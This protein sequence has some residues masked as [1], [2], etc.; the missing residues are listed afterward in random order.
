MTLLHNRK[1]RFAALVATLVVVGNLATTNP[2][3]ADPVDD[4]LAC[5]LV[6]QRPTL[7]AFQVTG[8]GGSVGC[9]PPAILGTV[10]CLAYNGVTIGTSCVNYGPN[11]TGPTHPE[12]CLPGI[13]TTVVTPVGGFGPNGQPVTSP[14]LIVTTEP[15]I[16]R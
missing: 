2:A 8:Y 1:S 3:A 9:R 10:V 4:I 13:W 11:V 5:R 15:C 14:P 7:A 12:R 16:E 6:A